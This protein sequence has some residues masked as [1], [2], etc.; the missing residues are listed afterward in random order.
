M[1]RASRALI[2]AALASL[3]LST[4]TVLSY[5]EDNSKAAQSAKVSSS[6]WSQPQREDQYWGNPTRTIGNDQDQAQM[7]SQVPS[8]PG[9]NVVPAKVFG[10][11]TNA[12]PSVA[13]S[14]GS[15]KLLD[16]GGA[17][18]PTAKMYAIYWGPTSVFNQTSI[19]YSSTV[20]G[21]LGGLACTNCTSGLTGMIK[22][23]S[24]TA[25]VNLSFANSWTD[26]SNPPS[27]A[28]ST[29][30]IA[31]EV[32]KVVNTQN[33][34]SIDPAGIYFVFTSNFPS[35]ASYC[36]WHGAASVTLSGTKTS[37]TF[38]YM[39]NL[40]TF[41]N[42]CGA[43]FLPH[44]VASTQGLAFD[45]LFNVTTHEL[46]ETM[47]DPMTTGYAFYDAAGY[48]IGDKC[49]WNWDGPIVVNGRTYDVQQEFSNTANS[50]ASS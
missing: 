19:T 26:T 41:L 31:N 35:R 49:A 30:A 17:V 12:K 48:E 10:I 15:G 44:Y 37:F 43:N 2:G 7:D 6:N 42:G 39:P 32:V 18:L 1:R 21:F 9:L 36:A 29:T 14:A 28:P 50:C 33:K 22:Q 40:A 11:R 46:Y 4:P 34:L 27:S 5:A 24:R 38:A 8:V 47:S 13:T 20:N 45:S 25:Q 23:Y 3:L 16:H